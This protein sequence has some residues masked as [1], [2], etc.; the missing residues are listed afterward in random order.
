MLS[1]L[2]ASVVGRAIAEDSE[3][4]CAV[5]LTDA[6]G[7]PSCARFGHNAITWSVVEWVG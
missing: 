5:A 4:H 2:D 6:K 7:N 1:G 3:L